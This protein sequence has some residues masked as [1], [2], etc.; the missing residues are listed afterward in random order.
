MI[1]KRAHGAER[2]SALID[3][4]LKVSVSNTEEKIRSLGA[5]VMAY[6]LCRSYSYAG[7]GFD[8]IDGGGAPMGGGL[9]TSLRVTTEQV[10]KAA[11]YRAKYA[12][13]PSPDVFFVDSAVAVTRRFK[14]LVEQF[15]LGLHFFV[16]IELQFFDG[17]VMPGEFFYFNCNVDIDCVLT[18]N[19]EEWFEELGGTLMPTL[20]FIQKLTPL[21]ISLSKPQIEGRHLWTGGILGWNQLFISDE[22]CVALRKNRIRE[23][24][25]RRECQEVERPWV[26][27]E[28]MGPLLDKWRDYVA[29]GRNLNTGWI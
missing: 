21:E 25:I 26:P 14:D 19:K 12:K 20:Q 28:H 16:P 17:S 24:E 15:E 27:E 23:I 3:S 4:V 10:S 13:P 2:H 7:P 5:S 8:W 6:W 22:F 29:S 9:S 1:M 18:D 11:R